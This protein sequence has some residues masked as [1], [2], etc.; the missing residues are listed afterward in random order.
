MRAAR[1]VEEARKGTLTS[2]TGSNFVL[3]NLPG[4]LRRLHPCW[5][6]KKETI[7]NNTTTNQWVRM[8][9]RYGRTEKGHGSDPYT[10]DWISLSRAIR[11]MDI[12]SCT[13]PRAPKKKSKT[14]NNN[15][16]VCE[17]VRDQQEGARVLEEALTPDK[18][19]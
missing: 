5:G 16:P 8:R 15:Q 1:G 2:Q 11:G 9:G 13:P 17:D 10:L 18:L 12:D 19:S 4:G 14:Q 6:S 3:I 7:N